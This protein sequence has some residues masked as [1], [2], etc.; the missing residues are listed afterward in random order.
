[1]FT[2]V[3]WWSLSARCSTPART[4]LRTLTSRSRRSSL[5]SRLCCWACSCRSHSSSVCWSLTNPRRTSRGFRIITT[6]LHPPRCLVLLQLS[7]LE[8]LASPEY[9]ISWNSLFRSSICSFSCCSAFSFCSL[10]FTRCWC[11]S[12]CEVKRCTISY[13]WTHE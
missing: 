1:M 2:S 7:H 11:V 9:F 12:F 3:M 13:R 10:S 5:A 6:H 8:S 4:V